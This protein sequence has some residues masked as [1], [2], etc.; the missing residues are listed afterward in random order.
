MAKRQGAL[1]DIVDIAANLPWWVGVLLAVVSYV[2]LHS[3]AGAD[4]AAPKSVQEMGGFAAQQIIRTVAMF[5]QY[6]MPIAFLAGAGLSVARGWKQSASSMVA[7]GTGRKARGYGSSRSPN[8]QTPV[9]TDFKA[10]VPE[11]DLY[12]VWK[13]ATSVG[14]ESLL[15]D[16][17]TWSI[18]LLNLLEWKRFEL[19][20][21][22]YFEV[23]G[24]KARTARAGADG[25]VDMHLFSEDSA[26]PNIIVQCKAW[27]T[28]KVGIKPMR[29]LL[30]VMTAEKVAEGIFVTTGTYTAEAR[31]F[32]DG[33]S[34]SL[35]DGAD[36]LGK[37]LALGDEQQSRLLHLAT[38]GD[39][40]TPTC[41]SCG[42]K[43]TTRKA[44]SDG[45]PFW[46]CVNYPRC[47]S[48]L[49]IPRLA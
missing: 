12:R 34:I 14:R 10:S 27:K 30:G 13:D 43:M 46:G 28:Y 40:T 21:A 29:E 19:L 5:A 11:D 17:K 22:G 20:C 39:F 15:V 6:V 49:R 2:V 37:L 4:F 24:F 33:K 41:P 26:T 36:L 31:N 23:L 42:I 8:P 48:T 44:K 45:E 38:G 18:D 7:S 47:R 9:P 3:I 16:T 1:E 35:I 32:A 25:G